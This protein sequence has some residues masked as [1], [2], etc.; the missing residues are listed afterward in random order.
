MKEIDVL[1]W[2][3]A[4]FHSQGWLNY[5]ME[6]ITYI[7]E[8]GLSV[9]VCAVILFIIKKTRIAGFDMAVGI[10]F[11]LL[12]VNVILK[13][14]VNRPRP[15]DDYTFFDAFYQQFHVRHPLDS[16]FPSGHTAICFCGAVSLLFSY[17][18]KALPAIIVAFLV[19]L[20]RIY[21][22]LHYPT[23][24]LGGA[25][26]GT[27]CGIG[28]HYAAKGILIFM[29]KKF[30]NFTNKLFGAPLPVETPPEPQ[31]VQ[32]EQA[33]PTTQTVEDSQD[34]Q[35]NDNENDA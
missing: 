34:T 33:E 8:F 24:V 16:S 25:L 7:G 26:I 31:E 1:K 14:A 15:Y 3:H 2:V 22:C 10:I 29:R 17:K 21:L 6:G 30:P 13:F 23:D 27:A 20:S 19:A 9:M 28:G 5:I 11:D 4:T 18:I 12:I 32:S 35:N